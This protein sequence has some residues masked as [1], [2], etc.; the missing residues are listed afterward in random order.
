MADGV[1]LCASAVD[2]NVFCEKQMQEHFGLI[3]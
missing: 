2:L 1:T 3:G